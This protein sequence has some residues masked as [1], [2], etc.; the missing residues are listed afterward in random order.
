MF[1][2]FG[3]KVELLVLVLI[4]VALLFLVATVTK[5]ITSLWVP[6]DILIELINKTEWD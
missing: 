3:V 5:V 2:G 1:V 6:L 4:P